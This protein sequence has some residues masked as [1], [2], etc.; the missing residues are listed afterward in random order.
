MDFIGV[1]A[2]F[3][4]SIHSIRH[5]LARAPI[6]MV[7]VCLSSVYVFQQNHVAFGLCVLSL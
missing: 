2:C 6:F 5:W 1:F 7:Y 4:C 3:F